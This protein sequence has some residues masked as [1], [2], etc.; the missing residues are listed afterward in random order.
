MKARW[1]GCRAGQPLGKQFSRFLKHSPPPT[2]TDSVTRPLGTCSRAVKTCPSRALSRIAHVFIHNSQKPKTVPMA[3][4]FD[5]RG[6]SAQWN[7]GNAKAHAAQV[8]LKVVT[9]RNTRK[10]HMPRDCI[11]V[12]FPA[13]PR[14]HPPGPEPRRTSRSVT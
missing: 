2:R 8:N 14:P 10:E 3:I 5:E 6:T 4:K 13:W 12:K 1:P 7:T 9:T 11:Y